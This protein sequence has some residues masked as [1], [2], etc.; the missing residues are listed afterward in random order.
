MWHILEHSLIDS[1]KILPVLFLVYVLIEIVEDKSS[2]FFKRN[3]KLKG[4][5]APIIASGVGIIPQCGFS[6]IATD[7]FSKKKIAMG[8]LISVFLATSDEAIPILLSNKSFI[9]PLIFLILIKLSYAILVGYI[10]NIIYNKTTSKNKIKY[11][12]Q[13][14]QSGFVYVGDMQ[15]DS[16]KLNVEKYSTPVIVGQDNLNAISVC[17]V[18][19]CGHNIE[20]DPSTLKKF[21]YHPLIHSLKIFAF[22]LIIN[23]LFGLLIH[24]VGEESITGFMQST[25]LFQPFVVSLIGLIP[26]CASSVLIS[27]LYLLGGINFGSCVAGLCANAGIALA[28]L[29]RQNP[30]SKE[31]I[32][33]VGLLYALSSILGFVVCLF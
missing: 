20:K 6:V 13:F 14:V 27:N 32:F 33:I 4:K 5:F 26:N 11:S 7:L 25:K 19:C 30:N 21:I 9:L 24:Y 28:V 23:I 31:N 12:T 1:L 18:G 8:T 22:I 3:K 10:V 17:D 2:N 29:F 16:S 15:I